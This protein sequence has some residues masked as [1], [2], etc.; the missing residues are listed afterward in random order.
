MINF[1]KTIGNVTQPISEMEPGCWIN[2]CA[3][4]LE[5]R[6]WLINSLDI[7]PEFL[8]AS[9]DEEES[10]HIENED[11]QTLIIIDVPYAEMGDDGIEYYTMPVGVISMP[12]NIVTVSIKDNSVIREFADGAIK[13]VNVALRTRFVL[14]ILLRMATRFLQHL[15]Q[16]DK[17]STSLESL[18]RKSMKNK[19]LVQLLDLQKSLVFFQTSLKSNEITIEKISKNR[20][21]PLYDE[22]QD[23]LEDV[24]IE[25]KQAIEMADIY[26]NILSG[27]MDAFASVISNNL[28]IV[29][30]VLTSLTVVMAIPTM[31]FSFYGMNIGVG[32]DALPFANSIWIPLAIAALISVVSTIVL[33]RKGM[34][35]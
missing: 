31:V 26:S 5:E 10:S 22:D 4:D 11:G 7:P 34:F 6:N 24:M 23:L 28:N 1:Y 33:S 9:L 3:P 12:K 14:Q 25:M 32:A 16:I 21:I 2:V 35:K 8:Q 29:M 17:N 15:K 19:E 20:V 18:L 13:G 30:K 27:T